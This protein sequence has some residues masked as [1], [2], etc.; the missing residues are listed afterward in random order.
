[1]PQKYYNSSELEGILLFQ[2]H[3]LCGASQST[4]ATLQAIWM[5]I[6]YLLATRVVGREL[7]RTDAGA[8][9]ALHLAGTLYMNVGE[10][11]REWSLFRSYPVGDGSHGAER[12]PGTRRI[13]KI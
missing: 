13:D 6:A 10:R 11:L 12:T 1:M 3:N 7:H 5:K 2:H 8:A 9:L 4:L